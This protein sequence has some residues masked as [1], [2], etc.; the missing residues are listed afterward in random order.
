MP[1]IL[2][3][4]FD[5]TLFTDSFPGPG[6]PNQPIIDQVNLFKKHGAGCFMDLQRRTLVDR[7][8]EELSKNWN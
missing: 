1:F 7:S 8:R 4:D 3:V 5:G 6:T 2:A